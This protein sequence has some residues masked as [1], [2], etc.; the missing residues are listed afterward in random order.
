MS[1]GQSDYK[2]SRLR[3]TQCTKQASSG[4]ALES[5]AVGEERLESG[6]IG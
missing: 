5:G 3:C 6:A 1:H 4:T 2:A